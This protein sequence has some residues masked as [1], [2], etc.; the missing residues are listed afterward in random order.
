MN[1]WIFAT[2]SKAFISDGTVSINV[3]TPFSMASAIW[4]V[5]SN[6]FMGTASV[7]TTVSSPGERVKQ[8]CTSSARPLQHSCACRTINDLPTNVIEEL[9][10]SLCLGQFLVRRDPRLCQVVGERWNDW[11][12]HESFRQCILLVVRGSIGASGRT[13][14]QAGFEGVLGREPL[15][16]SGHWHVRVLERDVRGLWRRSGGTLTFNFDD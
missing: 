5:S 15:E 12:H 11:G 2:S 1:G 3:S 6:A 14:I 4:G 7:L 16:D 13:R 10:H 8:F 9:P